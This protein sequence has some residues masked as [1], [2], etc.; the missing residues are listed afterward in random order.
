MATKKESNWDREEFLEMRKQYANIMDK[1]SSLFD[2]TLIT[3][4]IWA[5]WWS[6][7]FILNA[8]NISNKCIL[9]L[10]RILLGIAIWLTLWSFKISASVHQKMISKI[11]DEYCDK[12][13]QEISQ[14]T[15]CLNAV[16]DCMQ[17][18]SMLMLLLWMVVLSIFIYLNI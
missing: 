2:H 5:F 11:D 1:S 17:Y 18:A 12:D 4:S 16:L 7:L 14:K 6:M 8:Q 10:S 3:L 15:I 13:T 9:V